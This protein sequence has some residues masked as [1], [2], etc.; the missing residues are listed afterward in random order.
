MEAQLSV[1]YALQRLLLTPKKQKSH[2]YLVKQ[3]RKVLK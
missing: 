3:L 1:S 2:W